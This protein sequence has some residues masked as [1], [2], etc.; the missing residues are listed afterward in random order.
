MDRRQ[1]KTREAVFLAF[2]TLLE[3]KRDEHI[4]VQ[5]IIDEANIGR[6][7][8]YAHFETKDALLKAMCTD[9]FHHVFTQLLP[10]ETVLE[11]EEK[12]KSLELKLGH[13]LFHLKE[14]NFNIRRILR[15]ES[16]ELFLSYFKDYLKEL[17]Q[18]YLDDFDPAIPRDYLLH[19]LT[20]SFSETVKWWAAHDMD[21]EPELVAGYYMSVLR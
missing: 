14:N 16:C 15:S 1:Q 11:T 6:S 20:G 4:T 2:S 13:V 5:E 21:P 7:T 8:F 12:R 10:Q 17:F 19:H 18:Q 3:T 9:I